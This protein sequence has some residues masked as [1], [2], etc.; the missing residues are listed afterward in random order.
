MDQDPTSGI[1]HIRILESSGPT[2]F[3][4]LGS[5][6][7][8]SPQFD[9]YK[10]ARSRTGGNHRAIEVRTPRLFTCADGLLLRLICAVWMSLTG[11][12]A[13]TADQDAL[14]P[15][16]FDYGNTPPTQEQRSSLERPELSEFVSRET[17]SGRATDYPRTRLSD[18]GDHIP[19][20]PG[21]V[22]IA[23]IPSGLSVLR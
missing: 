11:I 2:F 4:N 10:D 14:D 16:L 19:N 6:V 23:V 20:S 1:D 18:S 12:F 8:A 15:S 17:T 9:L 3:N 22:L 5:P 13:R 21:G 7:Q